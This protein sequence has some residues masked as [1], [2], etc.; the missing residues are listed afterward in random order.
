VGQTAAVSDS[1]GYYQLSARA[2]ESKI[3]VS[4]AGYMPL[5][6]HK[7]VTNDTVLNFQ[8]GLPPLT[9]VTAQADV[10][11]DRS[12]QII[13]TEDL[14]LADPGHPGTPVSVPGYPSETASGGIKAPQ[15]FAPGVAGD[16]GEPIAQY[17]QIGDFYCPITFP[18]TLMGTVTQ[19]P[20]GSFLR[21]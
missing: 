20:T 7:H 6:I 12:S 3:T 15:Y 10:T 8:L 14:R 19:I 5:T 11:P 17:I 13:N 1:D 9:T 2:G 21:A 4:A 16:H 18:P